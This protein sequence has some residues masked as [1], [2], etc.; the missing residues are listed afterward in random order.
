MSSAPR[1][2]LTLSS[3][4]SLAQDLQFSY[5]NRLPSEDKLNFVFD[6]NVMW[7]YQKSFDHSEGEI[8]DYI[9]EAIGLDNA[10][11]LIRIS[12]GLV[13]SETGDF[14]M[15]A[16][17]KYE[18]DIGIAQELSLD[19][20]ELRRHAIDAVRKLVTLYSNSPG[21]TD[22]PGY[23][24][25]YFKDEYPDEFRVLTDIL[26]RAPEHYNNIDKITHILR[27]PKA[28]QA[29]PEL[30]ATL[31]KIRFILGEVYDRPRFS[32]AQDV[33]ALRDIALINRN[34]NRARTILLTF[35]KRL[36]QAIRLVQ[37]WKE[38]F[39]ELMKAE[40]AQ[41]FWVWH[42]TDRAIAQHPAVVTI[43]EVLDDFRL[44]SRQLFRDSDAAEKGGRS[45]W[46]TNVD[47]IEVTCRRF[48][49]DNRDFRS[50]DR[51]FS[52][53]IIEKL[54]SS[55]RER[56][57]LP[58]ASINFESTT[59]IRKACGQFFNEVQSMISSFRLIL[60]NLLD[61]DNILEKTL[62]LHGHSE[63]AFINTLNSE[64]QS[65][66]KASLHVLGASSLVA[67]R[68]IRAAYGFTVS[69]RSVQYTHRMPLP[70]QSDRFNL[71]QVI[72]LVLNDQ[73][74]LEARYDDLMNMASWGGGIADLTT[75]YLL[76]GNGAWEDAEEI[77]RGYLSRKI[78]RLEEDQIIYEMKILFAS[79]S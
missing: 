73:A 36:L 11:N 60:S 57:Q 39:A 76:A 66:A 22:L 18:T 31:D 16:S 41:T 63:E 51:S 37:A 75:A 5:E 9:T 1:Q 10:A 25:R 40:S 17:H 53:Q 55:L 44:K 50:S 68:T 19:Y 4:A 8:S 15:L 20:N 69:A 49:D 24:V 35:D 27:P 46:L 23:I 59:I 72:S 77:C 67:P 30:E 26:S 21:N 58:S 12:L 48:T 42:L 47:A 70:I 56:V 34:K 33:K 32:I 43:W 62:L 64:I 61:R 52:V 54:K 65:H 79:N 45:L 14:K 74:K 13:S 28:E 38:P 3:L 6:A 78:E 71:D 29:P 7:F 2:S